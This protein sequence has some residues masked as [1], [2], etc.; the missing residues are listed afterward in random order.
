MEP[1]LTSAPDTPAPLDDLIAC[2][3]CDVL[4]RISA[5][6]KGARARC[7]RCGT[8]LIAP[9]AGAFARIV[10]LAVTAMIL[11]S[12]AMFFPFLA[13]SAGGL[14]HATSILGAVL[15]F[16]SG[17]MVPLSVA[18]A[19][20]IVLIPLIRLGAIIYTLWPLTQNRPPFPGARRAFALAE[21]LKPWSMAEIFIVGVG[22]ALVK[23]SG[24][25]SVTLGPAFWAFAALVLVTALQDTF[26]CKHTV[27]TTLEHPERP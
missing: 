21:K 3:Y 6:P 5:V 13:L 23:I 16:S 7:K 15:A 24:M 11:M 9:R 10:S 20:L 4:H 14:H 17:L 12:A 19:G 18:V 2:P 27:W 22:V 26:M 25:A 1:V 8:V